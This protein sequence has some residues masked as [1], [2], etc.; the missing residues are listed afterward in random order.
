VAAEKRGAPSAS[1]NKTELYDE[2][3]RL[4]I[5]GRSGMSKDQLLKAIEAA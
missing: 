3:T 5:A 2:A 4:D 1:W